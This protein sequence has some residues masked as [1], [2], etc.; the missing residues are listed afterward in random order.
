M[1]TPILAFVPL[2]VCAP[3]E[4]GSPAAPQAV[5][6]PAAPQADGSPAAD[7]PEPESRFGDE[8]DELL[9]AYKRAALDWRRARRKAKKEGGEDSPPPHPVHAFL[10]RFEELAG[11]GEGQ[12]LL[13]VGLNV[14]ELELSQADV[15]AR[16]R[17]LLPRFVREFGDRPFAADL[18]RKI[19]KQGKWLSNEELCELLLGIFERNP[20]DDVRATAAYSLGGQYEASETE[21]GF[22]EA[23]KWYRKVMETFGGTKLAGKAK[24]R[25]AGL[26]IA[27]GR[28]A[29]DFEAQDVD[30][31]KFKLSDYRGKVVV[32]DFWGFW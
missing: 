12:A 23:A 6:S 17:E 14:Q 30:G 22:E 21:K 1:I 7:E 28:Q 24:G 29:P 5:G 2:L 19:S 32:L 3:H 31:T 11:R 27:V 26:N 8:Y 16:K 18:L 4:A 25:L 9:A 15:A 10:P 13:W 20:D